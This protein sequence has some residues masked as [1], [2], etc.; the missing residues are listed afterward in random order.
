MLE[1]VFNDSEKGSLIV[2]KNYDERNMQQGIIG[3][4]GEEPT[5]TERKEHFQGQAIGGKSEDVVNIGFSLDVGK[6][7]GAID[8]EERQN[9]FR[10]LWSHFNFDHKEQEHFFQ[11][12]RKDMEKLL[13]A[14]KNNIPIRIWKSDAPYSICGFY[15][16]C[17]ILRDIDCEISVVSLPEKKVFKDA[18]VVYNSWAEVEAGRFYQFLPFEKQ[19]SQMEKKMH[20]G[21]WQ[22]LIEENAPLRAIINGEVISVPEDFY[23]FII[24]SNL[25]EDD[26]ILGRFIG[27]LLGEYNLGISDSWYALRMNKMIEDN[28]LVVVNSKNLSHP[29][30]KVLRKI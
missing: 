23:D 10:N 22:R 2:A 16:V 19:L 14:A 18:I 8:G 11:N 20:S 17:Y 26:F 5:E 28:K 29:Y 13:N 7:S 1:V 3:H 12:Q 24:Q 30:E 21:Y 4:I 27:K 25:P 9:V 6:I 15:F